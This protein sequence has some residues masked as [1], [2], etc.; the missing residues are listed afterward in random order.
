V[1]LES[2]FHY[3]ATPLK[4]GQLL[5]RIPGLRVAVFSI[6]EFPP[7][8]ALRFLQL[9]A[10][11]YLD[12]RYGVRAFRRGVRKV[13]EGERHVSANV[14]EAGLRAPDNGPCIRLELTPQQ[15]AVKDLAVSG[16]SNPE[17]AAILN[18]CEKTV[19]N[20]KLEVFRL[21]NVRN[22]TGLFRELFLIDELR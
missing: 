14:R 3:S 12:L 11:S 22:V 13:L 8:K 7:D 15:E 4:M 19:E 5:K 21:Y 10:E 2:C 16:K 9:G 20:Y 1:F 18:V 17:M 6:G